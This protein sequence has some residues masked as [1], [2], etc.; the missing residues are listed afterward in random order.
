NVVHACKYHRNPILR[1][2][3]LLHFT[4]FSYSYMKNKKYKLLLGVDAYGITIAGILNYFLKTSLIYHSLEILS[5]KFNYISLKDK[6]IFE[7]IGYLLHHKIIK[8]FEKYF[9]RKAFVTIIQDKYR[10][11]LLKKINKITNPSE[12]IFV[13]NSPLDD[14]GSVIIDNDYLRNK[15]CISRDIKIVLYAG[16]LGE[17][18]GIDKVL[19]SAS[20][21]P[22]EVIFVIHGRGLPPFIKYLTETIGNIYFNKV[23]LS[24][25][26]LVENEYNMLIK[27]ADIGIV[28]YY[29]KEDPNVYTIGAGSGKLFYYLK[30]G[31]PVVSNAW[32]GLTEI[33]E[34]NQC[35]IC[36]NSESAIGSAIEKILTN[37]EFYSNN[38]IRCFELYEFSYHYQKLIEKI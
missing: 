15:Y 2:I 32:K 19:H 1:I 9:H 26:Q 22:R 31:L 27:S 24:L 34:T 7:R 6:N 28:W 29:D 11:K 33:V 38:A 4:L 12:A 36:V 13:P 17:W 18:T 14:R 3:S 16:S 35:G 37:Y 21:W 23:I 5:A 20:S 10:W 8:L 30:F 25:E